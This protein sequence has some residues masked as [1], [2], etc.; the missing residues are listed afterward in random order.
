[1]DG[2]DDF[3]KITGQN[4]D[5]LFLGSSLSCRAIN[6]SL[7]QK[8]LEKRLGRKLI[9]FRV[10]TQ[11]NQFDARYYLLKR[12]LKQ[13]TVKFVAVEDRPLPR[14]K[15]LRFFGL[16]FFKK[17]RDYSSQLNVLSR[18]LFDPLDDFSEIT[19]RLGGM[20][21]LRFFSESTV[22]SLRL[23]YW[24]ISGRTEQRPPQ[25]PS[26]FLEYDS[27]AQDCIRKNCRAKKYQHDVL[28]PHVVDLQFQFKQAMYQALEKAEINYL[29]YYIPLPNEEVVH[30]PESVLESQNFLLK[31]IGADRRD[32]GFPNIPIESIFMY[33]VHLSVSAANRYSAMLI[34]D[35]EEVLKR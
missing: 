9:I 25:K 3:S 11:Q 35:L 21:Y 8:E 28:D 23:I 26:E 15:M 16:E 14:K 5:L 32:L 29:N 33:G 20:A 4:I 27:V 34:P 19:Q 30:Q 2:S 12:I 6:Q 24:K 13:N 22:D 17:A 18:A 1:M 7:I 31:S 10:C